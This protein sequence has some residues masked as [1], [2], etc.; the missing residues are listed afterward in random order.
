MKIYTLI[1]STSYVFKI[2]IG[3]MPVLGVSYQ[4]TSWNVQTGKIGLACASA[5]C[6]Q[7]PPVHTKQSVSHAEW[8]LIDE[9]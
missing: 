1:L 3:N 6:D 7:S 5:Q 2:I 8:N 4:M 9:K